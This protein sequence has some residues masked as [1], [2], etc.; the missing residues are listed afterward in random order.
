MTSSPFLA[1]DLLDRAREL[2]SR[3]G[4][5]PATR[6][7]FD[8]RDPDDELLGSWLLAACVVEG[9]SADGGREVAAWRALVDSGLDAPAAVAAADPARL[10][11]VLAGAGH[12][13]PEPAGL[14][15]WRAG[16]GLLEDY[17]GSLSRLG[18]G[19]EGLEDLAGKLA[20][21]APGFGRATVTR[22]LQPLRGLWPGSEELPLDPAA[23]AAALHLEL[24]ANGEDEETAPARLEAI[25]QQG[26]PSPSL[27]D[28]EAALCRLGR[29][30]CLRE[31]S[32]RCPL[33]DECPARAPDPG[34]SR[35]APAGAAKKQ[36]GR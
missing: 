7:G 14:L 15:A 12:P 30:S 2:V 4:A 17:G 35:A 21:L 9:R 6:L 24:L 16:R 36:S 18:A 11:Q 3:F 8:L 34:V 31:R 5:H 22:F 19:A 28:L 27:A 10:V 33:A 32:D 29:R 23:R 26:E 1:N 20:R 13:R 25:L